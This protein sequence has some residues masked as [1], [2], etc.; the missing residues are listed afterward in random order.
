M[1]FCSH[2]PGKLYA[3]GGHDGNEHLHSAEMFDPATNSWKTI[4]PM[5][6]YR[7]T[8]NSPVVEVVFKLGVYCGDAVVTCTVEMSQMCVL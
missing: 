5:H 6:S 7:Y 2:L 3:V 1:L 4:A 8:Q